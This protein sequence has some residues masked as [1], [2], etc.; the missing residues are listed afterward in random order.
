MA[1]SRTGLWRVIDQGLIDGVFV[2]GTA[3]LSRAL[4]WVGSR[5]QTGQVGLY[6]VLFVLGA[7]WV[8]RT[9]TG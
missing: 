6:L 9:V 5:L 7:L 1:L 2:N 3:R 4:G 8:L